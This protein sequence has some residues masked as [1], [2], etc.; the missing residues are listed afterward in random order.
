ML[1]GMYQKL[2]AEFRK[3]RAVLRDVLLVAV[4]VADIDA[5]DPVA[6]CHRLFPFVSGQRLHDLGL[7][8]VRRRSGIG[9]FHHRPSDYQIIRP[10]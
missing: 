10:G 8:G 7:D 3:H 9:G 4:H 2:G 5:R 1:A 6:F